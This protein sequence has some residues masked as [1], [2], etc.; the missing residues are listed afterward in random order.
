[1][2][3]L[4]QT[5]QIDYRGTTVAISDYA[6]YNNE[7]LDN[8]SIICYD[9]SRKSDVEVINNLKKKFNV[10]AYDKLET[11]VSKLKPDLVYRLVSGD[12]K[13]II[14]LESKTVMHSVFQHKGNHI[15]AYISEWL[16]KTV[17]PSKPFVPHIVE[18][19][20]D[21]ER[22]FRKSLGIPEDAIVIGRHGGDTTFDIS[23]VKRFITDQNYKNVYFLFLGTKPF[24]DKHNVIFC[25]KTND[26]DLKNSFIETCDAMLHARNMGESFGL[27]VCEFLAHNK[28]VYAFNGGH[29]KNHIELLS[30]SNVN[31]LYNNEKELEDMILNT[32]SISESFKWNSLVEEFSPMNVMKKFNE[33][34]LRNC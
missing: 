25:N 34:F 4:F 17:D 21:D 32:K 23:F 18:R 13:E 31:V 12:P 15:D 14:Q 2:R 1:M 33:V 24:V 22:T 3:I 5:N 26:K 20:L 27:A 10:Y 16:S 7:F 29:D 19:P 30:K 28:P 6:K 8:E 11:L 9:R